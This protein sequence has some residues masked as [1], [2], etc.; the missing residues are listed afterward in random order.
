MKNLVVSI[1]VVVCLFHT[2]VGL[3]KT[4]FTYQSKESATDE[5]RDYSKAL[6][7]LALEKTIA[8]YG[9]YKLVPSGMMNAAR[10]EKIAK[11][12]GIENFI[13]KLS[14]SKKRMED[15]AFINFPVDRGIVGYRVFFVSPKV[16]DRLKNV[17]T[18]EQLQNFSIGQGIGWLD[19]DILNYNGFKVITGTTYE[20]LFRMVALG[21]FDLFPR[22]VNELY[23]EF[24]SH[25]QIKDLVFD[26]SIA[27]Y[28]PLPRFFFTTKKNNKAVSRI[29]EG[30]SV[31][32]K[33][34]SFNKLWEKYYLQSIE[35]VNLKHRK[36]IRIDNPFLKGL[37]NSY[38]KFVYR[39]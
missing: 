39:P 12:G 24:E 38:E 20:G 21:R 15:M 35:F 13:I 14:A 36:I 6:L 25:R 2:E 1:L 32:Y 16:K 5:R 3:T 29:A 22:G 28:Y 33:D 11:N 18:L 17:E 27:L 26:D 19:I 34:G 7:Q 10:S 8:Q 9:P 30:L 4:V 37:D 31:A 23:G